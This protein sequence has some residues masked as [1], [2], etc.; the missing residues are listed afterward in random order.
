M[1]KITVFKPCFVA[2]IRNA[3]LCYQLI[4]NNYEILAPTVT[5][6]MTTTPNTGRLQ[7]SFNIISPEQSEG[8]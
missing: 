4:E 8:A 1:G 7:D 2:D 6:T 5:A 3:M